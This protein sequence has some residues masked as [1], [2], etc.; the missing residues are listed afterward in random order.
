MIHFLLP[1]T[2]YYQ[3]P[4]YTYDDPHRNF[5]TDQARVAELIEEQERERRYRTAMQKQ[6]YLEEALERKRHEEMVVAYAALENRRKRQQ[7]EKERKYLAEIMRRRQHAQQQQRLME[8]RAR[9][10]AAYEAFR[11]HQT[12]KT[13]E[14]S[15][16]RFATTGIN[17][18][19]RI[20]QTPDGRLFKV[21]REPNNEV[22]YNDVLMQGRSMCGL[23]NHYGG[24]N[25]TFTSPS[26]DEMEVK[27]ELKEKLTTP[28]VKNITLNNCFNVHK[29]DSEKSK[30]DVISK[31]KPKR[32]SSIPKKPIKSSVLIGDVEDA[33]DSECE[34]EL[35]RIWYNRR[36]Q[37]GEW[38][39]PL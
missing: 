30:P 20:F 37:S 12:M 23:K 1:F 14:E 35:N 36:P 17:P 25:D 10:Q 18:T 34:D 19:F 31:P 4:H 24:P 7:E 5:I 8:E 3:E 32:K 9:K 15:S 38:I 26:D 11:R 33:S 22:N 2:E 13:R 27:E 16:K 29:I 21:L 28:E 6:A 39:E